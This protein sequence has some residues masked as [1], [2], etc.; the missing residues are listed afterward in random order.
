MNGGAHSFTVTVSG[1]ANPYDKIEFGAHR[2]DLR[3]YRGDAHSGGD[4]FAFAGG[5]AYGDQRSDLT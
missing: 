1:R 4:R 2:S 5:H 3:G